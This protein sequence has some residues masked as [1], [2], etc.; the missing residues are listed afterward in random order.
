MK[1][2]LSL[3]LSLA[4]VLGL[5]ACGGSAST[6]AP[7]PSSAAPAA[8]AA[9]SAAPA[10]KANPITLKYAHGDSES[11]AFHAGALVFKDLVETASDGE[12]TVDIYPAGQLGSLAEQVE[13]IQMGTIDV[14]S[15]STSIISNFNPDLMIFDFPFLFESYDHVYKVCDSEIGDGLAEKL[16]DSNIRLLGYWPIGFMKLTTS[17]DYPLDSLDGLANLPIR[18]ISN[19][20]NIST[21]R[22]LGAD[23][24]P[25]SWG[26]LFTALQQGTVVGQYNPYTLT[27]DAMV[28]EVQKYIY[29]TNQSFNMAALLFSPSTW[30]KL[31][32]EQQQIITDCAAKAT[33]EYRKIHEAKDQ[34]CKEFLT[35]EG[36]MEIRNTLDVAKMKELTASVYDQNPQYADMVEKIRAMA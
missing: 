31:T 32:P 24:V 18:V 25:M 30:N 8:P 26:E 7:A 34:E 11:S 5:A 17:K 21:W 16:L 27:K 23:A 14:T 36:G 4:L 1:K 22:A 33:T 29:E 12:I 2:Y 13:G 3:I 28:Y 15:V 6:T 9:S 10:P 35:T 19:D 20:L